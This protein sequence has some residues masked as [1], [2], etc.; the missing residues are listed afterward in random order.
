M[1]GL[2]CDEKLYAIGWALFDSHLW[3]TRFYTEVAIARV[4]RVPHCLRGDLGIEEC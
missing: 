2:Y 4:F 1:R 3:G